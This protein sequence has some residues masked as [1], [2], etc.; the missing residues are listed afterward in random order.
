[1]NHVVYYKARSVLGDVYQSVVT[2]AAWPLVF[3]RL[4]TRYISHTVKVTQ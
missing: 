2:A 1:M 4:G 3:K